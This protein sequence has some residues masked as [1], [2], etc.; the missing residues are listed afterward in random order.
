VAPE[1]AESIS[2]I[3]EMTLANNRLVGIP[4]PLETHRSDVTNPDIS[5][6]HWIL[7]NLCLLL[8]IQ[9]GGNV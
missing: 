9:N 2:E 6:G 1:R 8:C 7:V 5:S 3:K 4:A